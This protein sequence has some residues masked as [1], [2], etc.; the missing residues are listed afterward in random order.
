MC[1]LIK[2]RQISFSHVWAVVL[3]R[4]NICRTYLF[5]W[6]PPLYEPLCL[7]LCVCPSRNLCVSPSPPSLCVSPSPPC[8]FLC[9]PQVT[10]T[11]GDRNTGTLGHQDT[12]TPRHQDTRTLGHQ[13]TWTLGQWDEQWACYWFLLCSWN[14]RSTKYLELAFRRADARL[15][16]LLYSRKEHSWKH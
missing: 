7:C 12:R 11:L 4:L 15:M 16:P 9:P 5:S 14:Q 1:I 13:D 6:A 3:G 2:C 8:V 10:R